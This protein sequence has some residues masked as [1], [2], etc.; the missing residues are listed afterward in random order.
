MNNDY[1]P[2]VHFIGFTEMSQFQNAV[3]VFG[4]PDVIHRLWDRRAQIDVM[5][6]DTA[7]FAKGTEATP[8]VPYNFDDSNVM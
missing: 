5:P 4:Y 7:V 2:C 1:E 8:V 3:N 6:N